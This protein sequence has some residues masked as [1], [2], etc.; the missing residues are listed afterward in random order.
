MKGGEIANGRLD[1]IIIAEKGGKRVSGIDGGIIEVDKFNWGVD[2][3]N[4]ANKGLRLDD[5]ACV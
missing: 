1:K 2:K 3:G 5:I 4:I